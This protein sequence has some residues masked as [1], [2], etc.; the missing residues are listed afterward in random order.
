MR[1]MC[2][3]FRSCGII[4]LYTDLKR[5][6]FP[7]VFG[8]LMLWGNPLVEAATYYVALSGNDANSGAQ[9]GMTPWTA[10]LAQ[11]CCMADAAKTSCKAAQ[12]TTPTCLKPVTTQA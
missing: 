8:G 6:L 5:A 9:T 3:S 10:A 4:I 12:A 2:L 11:T 1:V 7:L